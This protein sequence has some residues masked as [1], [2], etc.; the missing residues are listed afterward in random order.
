MGFLATRDGISAT[1]VAK[2]HADGDMHPSVD[3][4]VS[5]PGMDAA[6]ARR[7]RGPCWRRRQETGSTP[8]DY[9]ACYTDGTPDQ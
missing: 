7:H 6:S 5:P 9:R 8:G 1:T 4:L 3:R 2:L